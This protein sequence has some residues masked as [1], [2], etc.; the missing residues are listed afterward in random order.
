[1][2]RAHR[3]GDGAKAHTPASMRPR[4]YEAR[5]RTIKTQ[6]ENLAAEWQ[7]QRARLRGRASDPQARTLIDVLEAGQAF[8]AGYARGIQRQIERSKLSPES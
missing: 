5:L 6:A 2:T 4:T 8:L 3:N 7:E 1:M